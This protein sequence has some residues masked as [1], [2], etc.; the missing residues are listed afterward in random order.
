MLTNNNPL[1]LRPS[2]QRANFQ[3][4]TSTGELGT[5]STAY[6][7][8]N[9]LAD[10][11]QALLLGAGK[12]S[13]NAFLGAPGAL[14][15][16]IGQMFDPTDEQLQ[17]QRELY[18]QSGEFVGLPQHLTTL[19]YTQPTSNAVTRAGDYLLGKNA[20]IQNNIRQARDDWLG[21]NNGAY[22]R[23]VEGIGAMSIPLLFDI[24]TDGVAGKGIKALTEAGAET[25]DYATD[26]YQRG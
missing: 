16:G 23:A 5:G 13:G 11:L 26:I 19:G 12:A 3:P 10:T 14:L 17:Q 24:A 21:G 9:F 20:E 7:V 22:A 15:K 6:S 25:G 1:D 2:Y 4:A 18:R 8:N